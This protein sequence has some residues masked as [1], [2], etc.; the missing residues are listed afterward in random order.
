MK[1][2]LKLAPEARPAREVNG[3]RVNDRVAVDRLWCP[4]LL[5]DGT[6][7]HWFFIEDA[8]SLFCRDPDCSSH[9]QIVHQCPLHRGCVGRTS[10]TFTRR[11]SAVCR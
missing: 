3:R 8:G 5:P 9:G 2:K 10:A 1:V 11:E 4:A 7:G 6:Q